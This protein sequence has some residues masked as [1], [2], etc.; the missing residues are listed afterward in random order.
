MKDTGECRRLKRAEQSD[1]EGERMNETCN[2]LGQTVFKV[3]MSC[4]PQ[5]IDSLFFN[6]VTDAQELACAQLGGRIFPSGFQFTPRLHLFQPAEAYQQYQH[7][8]APSCV[9]GRAAISWQIT[10]HPVFSK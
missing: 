3:L 2:A 5:I 9:I 7:G 6:L 8:L 10:C 4:L 1:L